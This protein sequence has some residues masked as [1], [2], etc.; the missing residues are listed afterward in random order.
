MDAEIALRHLPL[1][2]FHHLLIF[3]VAVMWWIRREKIG[4]FLS[5]YMALAFAT[6]TVALHSHPAWW[7]AG[8]LVSGALAIAWLRE[9]IHPSFVMSFERTPRPRLVLMLVAAGFAVA[10]PGHSGDLPGFIFSPL[11]VTVQPTLL[12][13]LALLNAVTPIAN[14][15][16]RLIHAI[17]G[18]CYGV[19][20]VVNAISLGPATVVAA[21]VLVLTSCYTITLLIVGA[22]ETDQDNVPGAVSIEQLRARMYQ[23]RTFLPGPRDPRRTSRKLKRRR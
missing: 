17:A 10:Y 3:T 15:N 9:T 5:A 22:R 2:G 14:R 21:S 6:T 11:G 19:V 7:L 12:L 23:R 1:A 16:L 13:A 8:G 4:R 20:G 18:I